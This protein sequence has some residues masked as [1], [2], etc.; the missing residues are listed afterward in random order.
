ML[1]KAEG[2]GNFL[3]GE[4]CISWKGFALVGFY[5][6]FPKLEFVKMVNKMNVPGSLLCRVS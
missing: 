2:C 5:F 1:T 3:L 6:T 4:V